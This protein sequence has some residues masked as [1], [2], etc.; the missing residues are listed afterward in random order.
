VLDESHHMIIDE[1]R[2]ILG[3]RYR[4]KLE[5][6]QTLEETTAALPSAKVNT[7]HQLSYNDSHPTQ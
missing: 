3:Y 7:V 4:I 6:L 5:Y 2:E 1:R